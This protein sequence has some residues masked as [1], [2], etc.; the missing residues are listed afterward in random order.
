MPKN[1]SWKINFLKNQFFWNLKIHN[2]TA[3]FYVIY[4]HEFLSYEVRK[5]CKSHLLHVSYSMKCI[6]RAKNYLARAQVEF[7]RNLRYFTTE[8]LEKRE[9]R[10]KFCLGRAPNNFWRALCISLNS[11]RAGN[12]ICTICEPHNSKTRENRLLKS[13]LWNYEFSKFKKL[14]F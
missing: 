7:S 2:F 11:S 1:T 10:G 14:I 9:F 8:I 6:V 12:A 5:W 3:D 13:Q 4:F